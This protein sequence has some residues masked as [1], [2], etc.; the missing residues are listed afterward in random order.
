M[1]TN[2]CSVKAENES[3]TGWDRGL[4]PVSFQLKNI[5]KVADI[6]NGVLHKNVGLTD[7]M[8]ATIESIS[9]LYYLVKQCDKDFRPGKD[10]NPVLLDENRNA[11]VRECISRRRHKKQSDRQFLADLK[12]IHE[13]YAQSVNDNHS[14]NK[15]PQNAEKSNK[16]IP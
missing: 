8:S 3:I 2:S 16:K 12:K 14:T 15:I 13:V 5:K 4:T 9:D 10:V 11:L 1:G 7:E 6:P